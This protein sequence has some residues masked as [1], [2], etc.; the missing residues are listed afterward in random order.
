M[1]K[2][3]FLSF[4]ICV[5]FCNNAYANIDALEEL[6]IKLF[7]TCQNINSLQEKIDEQLS[8]A[9]K[10]KNADDIK[11]FNTLHSEIKESVYNVERIFI[12]LINYKYSYNVDNSDAKCR[13]YNLLDFTNS[14]KK[15]YIFL[16]NNSLEI[17]RKLKI[18]Q[19]DI[20]NLIQSIDDHLS[21][22]KN[23]EQYIINC[24]EF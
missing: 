3:I 22:L 11:L 4:L 17:S 20:N 14:L 12:L 1:K 21:S 6:T 23:L 24:K 10:T 15:S 16:K 8:I 13:K 2:V 5:F 9:N 7:E 18:P 19:K